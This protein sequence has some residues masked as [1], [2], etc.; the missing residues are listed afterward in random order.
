MAGRNE[1]QHIYGFPFE[2]EDDA[3]WVIEQITGQIQALGGMVIGSG[4]NVV[5]SLPAGIQPEQISPLHLL[6]FS[7]MV[8]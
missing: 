6:D 1:S 8:F 5:I 4:G 7:V 2:S 3:T